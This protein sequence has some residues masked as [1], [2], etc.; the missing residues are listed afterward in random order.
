[1]T[2]YI[3]LLISNIIII[4][5]TDEAAGSSVDYA[6]VKQNIKIAFALELRDL[7]RYGFFL[8]QK[9]ILPACEETF[10]GLVGAI[11]ALN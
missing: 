5:S 11:Q 7:G 4:S 6:Y 1:M 10:D 8:P 2:Q 9:Q 3:I